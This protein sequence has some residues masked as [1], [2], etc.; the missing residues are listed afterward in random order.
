MIAAFTFVRALFPFTKSALVE[1]SDSLQ[2]NS[3]N[4]RQFFAKL[5]LALYIIFAYRLYCYAH[6][7]MAFAHIQMFIVLQI[8]TFQINKQ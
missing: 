4:I 7:A 8:S 5:R 6:S 3:V 2:D 1:F